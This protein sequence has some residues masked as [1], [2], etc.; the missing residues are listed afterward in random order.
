MVRIPDLMVLT[1]AVAVTLQGAAR[2]IVLPDMSPPALVVEVVS[3]GI[4]HEQQDY[5]YQRSPLPFPLM[6]SPLHKTA[7]SHDKIS[8]GEACAF[9]QHLEEKHNRTDEISDRTEPLAKI[10]K[11]YFSCLRASLSGQRW[12]SLCVAQSR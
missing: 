7:R 8:V 5:C 4:E 2:S 6:I 1:E 9:A 10:C 3:P 12:R 11:P